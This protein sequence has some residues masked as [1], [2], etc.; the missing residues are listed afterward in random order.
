MF[1]I[2]IEFMIGMML[3]GITTVIVTMIFGSETSLGREYFFF[4]SF[5]ILFFAIYLVK[6]RLS[7]VF[8]GFSIQSLLLGTL[9][10]FGVIAL[11]YEA[12][13]AYSMSYGWAIFMLALVK[14]WY[15]KRPKTDFEIALQELREI[16][17]KLMNGRD[18]EK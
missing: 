9:N 15:S 7:F 5:L 4:I 11:T 6:N 13:F 18:G 1:D 14:W 2:L 12:Y 8:L 10:L 17:L 16:S 3:N